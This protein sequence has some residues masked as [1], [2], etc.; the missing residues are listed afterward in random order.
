M[1]IRVL[2][3]WNAGCRFRGQV[4]PSKL[5]RRDRDETAGFVGPQGRPS[6]AAIA[7]VAWPLLAAGY[8]CPASYGQVV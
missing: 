2:L 7:T 1:M 8:R 3:A 4:T 5:S 6:A